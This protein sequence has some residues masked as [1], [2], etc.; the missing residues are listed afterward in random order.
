MTDAPAR[1]QP[2]PEQAPRSAKTRGHLMLLEWSDAPPAAPQP[3]APA[4]PAR[5]ALSR[6]YEAGTVLLIAGT[7]AALV[8]SICRF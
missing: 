4:W 8:A 6:C 5:R 1:P 2:L 3:P 7:L